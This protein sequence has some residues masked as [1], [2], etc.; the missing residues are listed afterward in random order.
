[1]SDR[2]ASTA[3]TKPH[4]W[5]KAPRSLM[6]AFVCSVCGRDS[7]VKHHGRCSGEAGGDEVKSAATV[8]DDLLDKLLHDAEI[9]AEYTAD[10]RECVLPIGEYTE[11]VRDAL[12]ELKERRGN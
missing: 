1:V 7:M 5:V 8:S 3:A 11:G 4:K 6:A 12:R 2:Q 9:E 10:G